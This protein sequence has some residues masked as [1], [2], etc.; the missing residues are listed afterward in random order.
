[1]SGGGGPSQT[2]VTQSNIPDW[3]RP[4]VE[5]VLGGALSEQFR[6]KE[7]RDPITGELL[8]D[9]KG[10][11]LYDITGTKPFVP[12]SARPEDYVAGFS[13]LQQQAQFNIANLQVPQQFQQGT[14][15]AQAAGMGALGTTGQAAGYGSAGY[16]SGMQ[17]QMLGQMAAQ[18]AAQQAAQAQRAAY[19]YGGTGAGYGSQAAGLAPQAQ[20]YGQTAADIGQMALQAQRTGQDIGRTAQDY[21]RLAAT[22]GQRYTS[23]ATSPFGV[24]RFMSPYT[25]AVTDAQVAAA[26]RQAN[27]ARTQRQSQA[28]RAGAFG[29]AR[30]AIEQAEADRALATQLDN[31]RAAGLQ[32]A[33]DKAVQ[34]QQF[35]A[36]LGLQGLGSAQTGLGTA[37]QGGQLGLSGIGQAM[38]GQQ[39]GLAGLGQA[40]QLYGLGMQ[41][42]G[43]GLSGIDRAIASGQ[44]GLQGAGVGLQGTGQGIQGA[45]AGLQ[46]VTG[47]QAGFNLANQAA[48][49]LG[50]LGQQQ[51]AAQTGILGLQQQ[52]G[53][54]QQAQQQQII[55]QAIQ[56]YA[57][58]REAPMQAFN[59]YNALLRGYA[60]PGTTATQYQAQPTLSNQ[61]VGLGTAG[62][63]AAQLSNALGKKKG[64]TVR[65]GI[66]NLSLYNAMKS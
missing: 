34:A 7:A 15:L 66:A 3:L 27:I 32:Q 6:T 1:M 16:M 17:G 19:G 43:V 47:Q 44:L 29:G 4:Q 36:N 45:Q 33:Y 28:A 59:Q 10:R 25:S 23:E 53:A 65:S 31:I 8:K 63:G 13:P 5:T 62:I 9:D 24:S 18:R 12:Y 40:G 20:M 55:N 64:G 2:T 42:A 48:G 39:A 58:A 14:G 37:L 50:Q 26:Q 41:G 11:Q 52:A 35:G 38:A 61:L 54:Q 60:L 56:N 22:A 49:Q 21:A 46:G 57:Q 30:Q 51:L